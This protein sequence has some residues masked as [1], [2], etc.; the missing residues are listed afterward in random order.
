[1]SS[2]LTVCLCNSSLSILL[3]FVSL[4]D[5][6]LLTYKT[7]T[8]PYQNAFLWYRPLDHRRTCILPSPSLHTEL[9]WSL[10]WNAQTKHT[11]FIHFNDSPSV[12][13]LMWSPKEGLI[14]WVLHVT[15]DSHWNVLMIL[16]PGC[17]WSCTNA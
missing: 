12:C 11:G 16:Q 6:W 3:P 8:S 2:S 14:F 4:L 10:P 7:C 17:G 5:W 1:M 15:P 9:C 13:V